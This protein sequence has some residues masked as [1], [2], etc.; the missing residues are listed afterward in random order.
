MPMA[1]S[2]ATPAPITITVAGGIFP[3]AVIWPVKKRPK[4]CPA[5]ITARYPAMLD[6]EDSASIFCARE[7]RGTA[8]M[9]STV[10][11]RAATC[12]SNARFC[13]GQKKLMRVLPVVSRSASC[14]PD[15]PTP[16]G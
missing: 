10:A 13:A 15:L 1:D 7:M 2:P 5:S 16:G 9:A 8:S 4:C 6:I 3:A 12:S 14:S 11:P